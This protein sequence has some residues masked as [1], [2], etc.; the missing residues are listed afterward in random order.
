MSYLSPLKA[1]LVEAVLQTFDGSYPVAAFRDVHC[2]IEYPVEPQQYP[3]IWVDY[4]DTKPLQTAGVDHSETT[5]TGSTTSRY[6]RWKFAGYASY[7][8]AAL[9][10]LERDD[11]FGEMVRVMAFG[12]TSPMTQRFRT[13]IESNDLI[14]ANFDFDQVEVR[15]NA[16]VPGTPWGTDEIIYERT[17]SMEVVGEFVSDAETGLL[18]PLSMINILAPD[19]VLDPTEAP[20]SMQVSDPSGG[21]I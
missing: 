7:T 12:D 8:I 21:W 13:Y 19:V 11:L 1:L 4:D 9:T 18:V 10:S 16:A 15:G 6:R 2:S 3:G 14:A 5:I 17:L 20:P